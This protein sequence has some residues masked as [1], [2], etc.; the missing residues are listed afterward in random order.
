MQQQNKT[1][2]PA[3]GNFNGRA[4]IMQ[5]DGTPLMFVDDKDVVSRPA[6]FARVEREIRQ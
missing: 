4:C 5:E 2:A 3:I 6:D 1:A